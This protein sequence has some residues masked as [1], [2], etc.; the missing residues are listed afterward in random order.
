M[1]LFVCAT[2]VAQTN[3]YQLYDYQNRS[4]GGYQIIESNKNFV[5]FGITSGGGTTMKFLKTDSIG[6][7]LFH[8]DYLITNDRLWGGVNGFKVIMVLDGIQTQ[9]KEQEIA[10]LCISMI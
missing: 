1:I 9:L 4:D 8:K 3:F 7:M 2:V 5:V 10:I 6:N